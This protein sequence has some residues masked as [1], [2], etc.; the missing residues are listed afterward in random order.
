MTAP[1]CANISSAATRDPEMVAKMSDDDIW[2]LRRGGHDPQKVYAAYHAAVNQGPAHGAADQDRQGLRHGQD[3]KRAMNNVHQTKKLTDE[4][5]KAFRDRFNIP[6]RT[7]RWPRSRSSQAGRRHAG[8]A[9]P[10]RT[11]QGAGRLPAAPPHQADEQFTVPAGHFQIGDRAHRG[12]PR[13]LHHPGL[14]ALPDAVAARP[15]PGPARG[16]HPGGRGPHLRHGRPVPPGRH[17]Q[18]AGPAVHPGR[19]RTR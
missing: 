2:A 7:A 16:A 8:N 10:A 15:G 13:D 6:I 11:P 4:D 3:Q 17:L 1:T 14:R 9:V 5:I 18:P 12:R 19:Q